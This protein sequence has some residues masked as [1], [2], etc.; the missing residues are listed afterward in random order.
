MCCSLS[1]GW[2]FSDTC[3]LISNSIAHLD[4]CCAQIHDMWTSWSLLADCAYFSCDSKDAFVIPF[5]SSLAGFIL[6]NKTG[7]S[8]RVADIK[9][10]AHAMKCLTT[11]SEAVGPG[12]IFERV[13]TIQPFYCSLFISIFYRDFIV[14]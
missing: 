10:R 9:T 13:S 2:V 12:F 6:C 4:I 14:H 11:F 8:E 3:S 1:S 7:I 5:F